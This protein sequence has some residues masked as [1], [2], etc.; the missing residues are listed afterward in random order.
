MNTIKIVLALILDKIASPFS[1]KEAP[2]VAPETVVENSI[3]VHVEPVTTTPAP[4]V[5]AKPKAKK[6]STKKKN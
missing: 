1:K 6:R 4:A 3:H 2:A 5:E